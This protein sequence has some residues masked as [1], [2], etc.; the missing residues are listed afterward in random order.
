MN[1]FPK[2]IH[3]RVLAPLAAAIAAGAT[4][5]GATAAPTVVSSNWAGYV[6]T[7]TDATTG[8]AQSFKSVSGTWTQP[9]AN[10]TTT[11]GSAASA[12][13][14][15]LGG[16]SETSQSLEQAGTEVD[17][18]A[19]GTAVYSA[20]Y[21]LVPSPS[22][23]VSLKVGAGDKM[24]GSVK[25]NGSKVTVVLKNL[26]R[27]SSFTKTLT[28]AS[29]DLSSAEWIAEAPSA[30]T[31]SGRCQTV[32]LTNFG[33]VSFAGAQATTAGGHTGTISDSLWSATAIQ[34]QSQAGNPF[35]RF[36]SQVTA[37]KAVPSALSSGGSA[38]S[39]AWS[40]D[41]SSVAPGIDSGPGFGPGAFG[42]S[43]P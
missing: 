35:N 31:S 22:V 39:V 27:K 32:P 12:F 38:F 18:Q 23:K 40:T 16:N 24:F 4:A 42:P 15:G 26:T 34:L 41:T 2:L 7:G 14:V 33:T 37:T 1:L 13:W 3:P 36:A 28:M 25:V 9:A 21:E 5:L 8:V 30:C 20:W 43:F 11:S 17:C 29:P 10:C 6:V 19:N